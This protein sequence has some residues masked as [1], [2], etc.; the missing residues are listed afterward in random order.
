MSIE[1]EYVSRFHDGLVQ[2]RYRVTLTKD[3][4]QRYVISEECLGYKN[5]ASKSDNFTTAFRTVNGEVV[6]IHADEKDAFIEKFIPKTTNLVGNSSVSAL[7]YE[8]VLSSKENWERWYDSRLAVNLCV[9]FVLG[10]K[11]HVYMEQ[12]DDHRNYFMHKVFGIHSASDNESLERHFLMDSYVKMENNLL[13]VLAVDRNYVS[14]QGYTLFEDTVQKLYE[15]L[16][17]F[18]PELKGIEIERRE[19]KDVYICDLIMVYDSYRI[20]AEFESTGIKKLIKLYAYLAEMVCGG[21]VFID[22]FDSNLHDVY[23]CALLEYLMEY[24]QGQLC[25]TTHNVGPMDI[26]RR[27]K[28]SIDFLSE[29][30]SVYPWKTNGNYSPSKLYRGGMIEGSPFNVDSIDFLSA[31]PL[32]EN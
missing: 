14:K 1:A 20:H 22:E 25:F 16:R 2:Y 7:F 26:L 24:G 4:T 32:E 12:A 17:I 29:D 5:A 30:N 19:D 10:K 13:E 18:K 28:K 27:N 8:K 6:E 9:A 21:I 31:F 23:L 3:V 15:F 11:L